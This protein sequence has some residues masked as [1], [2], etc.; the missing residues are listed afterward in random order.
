MTPASDYAQRW[1]RGRHSFR[2]V[3]EG[4]FDRRRYDVAPIA[5]SAARA[6]VVEHHYA[7]SFPAARLRYGLF[8]GPLLVGCAVLSVPVRAQVLTGVFPDLAPYTE[9]LEL[10]RMV[11]LDAVPANAESWCIARVWELAAREGIRGVVTFSD[12]LPRTASD[13]RTVMPGHIG[14]IYQASNARYLGR[15]TARTLSLLPDGTVLND[16]T[17]Q[18]IR[19]DERGHEAAERLLRGFGAPSRGVSESG[20]AWL[21]RALSAVGVRSLRHPGNHRYAFSLTKPRRLWLVESLPYPKALAA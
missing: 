13:G 19:G 18:K 8:D 7:H 16:R 4:G 5:E 9:S 11:L 3:S 10:G 21:Q 20:S 1:A 12:P 2:H 15:A 6:F 17:V 14:T